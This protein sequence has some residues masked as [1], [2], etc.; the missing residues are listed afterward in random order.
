MQTVQ[1][2]GGSWFLGANTPGG[3][4]SLFSELYDPEEGWRLVIVKGGPGTGKSSLMKRL[5]AAAEQRGFVC[6][7]IYC[8]SDPDS[9]DGVIIPRLKLS[10]A[11]G[12][13]PHVLEPRYPGVSE[14]ILDLGRFRDDAALRREADEIIALTKANAQAHRECAGFLKAAGSV[15]NEISLLVAETLEPAKLKR[16]SYRLAE[17][18]CSAVSSGGGKISRR[19]LSAPTPQGITVFYQSFFDLCERVIVLED[20]F[21]VAA[22]KILS[23]LAETACH[24]GQD[25]IVCPCPMRPETRTEHL[26]LPSLGLGVCT[27]NRWHPFPQAAEK[28]VNC[29]R[30]CREEALRRRKNRLHFNEKA[31]RE[32]LD[33]ALQKQREAKRLHDELERRYIRAMDFDALNAF[34]EPWIEALLDGGDNA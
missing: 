9:L 12:T 3:F 28:K 16:F 6:E 5:A 29:V 34:S 1:E 31:E 30:F 13:A 4:Y 7:R 22:A 2:N 15:E 10:V 17:K 33:A 18:V 14:T 26:L 27:S 25:V 19:F 24:A 21:G 11:D 32:L 8:S 20:A 23:V